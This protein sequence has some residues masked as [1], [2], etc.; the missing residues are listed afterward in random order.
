MRL[1]RSRAVRIELEKPLAWSNAGQARHQ[2]G[3][4]FGVS[5]PRLGE[6]LP[7]ETSGSVPGSPPRSLLCQGSTRHRR[8]PPPP[9]R[10]RTSREPVIEGRMR[11]RRCLS[12][13][14]R[15]RHPSGN[16]ARTGELA[17]ASA[18]PGLLEAGVVVLVPVL[19]RGTRMQFGHDTLPFLFSSQ[20]G[21]LSV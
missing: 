5:R 12:V 9:P 18:C 10:T 7:S 8:A 4:D 20:L 6:I 3:Q 16:P 14:Q 1:W 21:C 15:R 2:A 11:R 13:S 19:V 17:G